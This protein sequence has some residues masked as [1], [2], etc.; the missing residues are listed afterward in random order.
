MLVLTRKPEEQIRIG[1]DIVITIVRV[2]GNTIRVGVEAPKGVRVIRGELEGKPKD[3]E[4][5]STEM[6]ASPKPA[7]A[8]EPRRLSVTPSSN[9]RRPSVDRLS[10]TE[11]SSN[12]R[13]PKVERSG[14]VDRSVQ[15]ASP[16]G[17]FV[18]AARIPMPNPTTGLNSRVG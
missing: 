5:T 6:V 17:S 15:N 10:R 4:T 1:D 7:R 3:N 11:R 18:L 16:L 13:L 2:K 12:D 9:D 14:D 8:S